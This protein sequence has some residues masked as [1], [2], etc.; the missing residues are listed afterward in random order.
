MKKEGGRE[1]GREKGREGEKE[2]GGVGEKKEGSWEGK[3]KFRRKAFEKRASE[4]RPIRSSHR[5]ST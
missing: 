4:E 5:P 3:R 2:R 1:G